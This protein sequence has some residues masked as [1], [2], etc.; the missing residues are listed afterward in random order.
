MSI[1]TKRPSRC[2]EMLVDS[3]F[4]ASLM[5]V[6]CVWLRLWQTPSAGGSIAK[7]PFTKTCMSSSSQV[8]LFR[9]GHRQVRI[10]A[11][12]HWFTIQ[13]QPFYRVPRSLDC[14]RHSHNQGIRYKWEK[15]YEMVHRAAIVRVPSLHGCHKTKGHKLHRLKIWWLTYTSTFGVVKIRQI[16]D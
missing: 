5:I 11:P 16:M 8:P 13:F 3:Y 9:K 6:G 10:P 12:K 4:K 7:A 1:P 2:N 14:S 15:F